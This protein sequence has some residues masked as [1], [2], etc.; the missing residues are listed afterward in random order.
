MVDSLDLKGIPEKTKY[1]KKTNEY[2]MNFPL[3]IVCSC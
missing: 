1:I 2:K 3:N